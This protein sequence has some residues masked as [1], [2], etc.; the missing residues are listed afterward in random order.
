MALYNHKQ[1]VEVMSYASRELA[2]GL[3][4]LRLA[5][6]VREALALGDVQRHPYN[7]LNK[8]VAIAERLKVR[9]K[10]PVLPGNFAGN[11]LAGKCGTMSCNGRRVTIVGIEK[12]K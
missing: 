9:F 7:T 1:I 4:L 12:L 3:H 8:P 5:Q 2:D 10:A 11:G 6:L